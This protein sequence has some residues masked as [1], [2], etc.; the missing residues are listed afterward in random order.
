[1]NAFPNIAEGEVS[2]MHFEHSNINVN[3]TDGSTISV[4]LHRYPRLQNATVEEL[5]DWQIIGHG[6]GIVWDKIDEHSS[7]NGILAGRKSGESQAS[8]EKWLAGRK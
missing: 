7:I 1:M 8:F 3:L 6:Y 4:P 2:S 5:N